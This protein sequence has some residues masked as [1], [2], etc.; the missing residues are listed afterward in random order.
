MLGENIKSARESKGMTQQE[1]ADKLNVVR[2]TVSK[3]EKNLSVPDADLLNKIG[4]I[5][6]VDIMILL[7]GK[8]ADEKS[9]IQREGLKMRRSSSIVFG[10]AIVVL[11]IVVTLVIWGILF[12]NTGITETTT[13]AFVTPI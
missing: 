8:C 1:L 7:D 12:S 4:T 11:C 5:L 2:Q 13:D 3:W 10:V 6:N 9:E